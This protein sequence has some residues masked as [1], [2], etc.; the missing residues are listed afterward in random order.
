MK[1]NGKSK[2]YDTKQIPYKQ[3]LTRKTIQCQSKINHL[4]V[5]S[6][7]H[8]SKQ[9]SVRIV[10]NRK[11]IAYSP[12]YDEPSRNDNIYSLASNRTGSSPCKE[13]LATTRMKHAKPLNKT[14]HDRFGKP[15]TGYKTCHYIYYPK[16]T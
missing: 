2:V 11:P 10:C 12:W 13:R 1:R 7:K 3:R 5:V 8:L 15:Y 14:T 16:I 9:Y 4:H 6:N